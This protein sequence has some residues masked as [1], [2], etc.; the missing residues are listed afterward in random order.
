MSLESGASGGFVKEVRSQADTS[1]WSSAQPSGGRESRKPTLDPNPLLAS[2]AP[3]RLTR[4]MQV[5][6]Y[7]VVT[8]REP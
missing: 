5:A 3:Q 2:K 7:G 6:A 8:R 4:R 1:P